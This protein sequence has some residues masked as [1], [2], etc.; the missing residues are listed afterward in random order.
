MIG[1]DKRNQLDRDDCIHGHKIT[2][3]VHGNTH[4]RNFIERSFLK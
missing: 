1:P 4:L 3:R 2:A